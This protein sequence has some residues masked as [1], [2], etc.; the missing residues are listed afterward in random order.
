[1][2]WPARSPRLALTNA[3]VL[4]RCCCSIVPQ[5]ASDI[6]RRV[7]A[8]TASLRDLMILVLEYAHPFRI[9]RQSASSVNLGLTIAPPKS[10]TCG[11]WYIFKGTERQKEPG[12]SRVQ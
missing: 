12:R 1:M 4:A 2:A 9:V 10:W 11:T 5:P 3:Q 8:T 6:A 7:E